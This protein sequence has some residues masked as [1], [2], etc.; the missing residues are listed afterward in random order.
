[1]ELF[2]FREVDRIL[3]YV[4]DMK[5]SDF[6]SYFIEST[7]RIIIDIYIRTWNFVMGQNTFANK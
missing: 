6:F 3:C 4:P 7:R 1:M 2:I 5:S